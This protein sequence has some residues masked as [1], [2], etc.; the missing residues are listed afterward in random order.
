MA[1][2]G[3]GTGVYT[4]TASGDSMAG[5]CIADSLRWIGATASGQVC[6]ITDTAGHQI[7]YSEADGARFIDG[8]VFPRNTW[9]N[10]IVAASMNSGRLQVY[11]SAS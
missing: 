8:W 5:I 6:L 10:G 9:V 1:V 11:T 2:T 4:F 7:F 3:T